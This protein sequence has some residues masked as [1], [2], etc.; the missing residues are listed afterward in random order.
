MRRVSLFLNRFGFRVPLRKVCQLNSSAP[1][2]HIFILI[3]RCYLRLQRLNSRVRLISR[4][5]DQIDKSQADKRLPI[6]RHEHLQHCRSVSHHS[7]CEYTP[8]SPSEFF[9]SPTFLP[10]TQVAMVIASQQDA[11]FVF[12]ALAVIFCCF[13]SMLLIFVPKVSGPFVCSPPASPAPVIVLNWKTL[14]HN[15]SASDL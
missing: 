8:E 4:L 9:S 12:V 6:C 7:A 3:C 15:V 13:L 5:R 1:F 2:H 14:S 11:S 10:R